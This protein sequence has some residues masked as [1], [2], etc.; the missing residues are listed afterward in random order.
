MEGGLI[1][2]VCGV[3][4]LVVIN[5]VRMVVA[6]L[7]CHQRADLVAARRAVRLAVGGYRAANDTTRPPGSAG[8][9][10]RRGPCTDFD[11]AGPGGRRR[12]L[13]FD[14]LRRR[15]HALP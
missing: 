3:F 7:R 11:C 8:G 2:G 14:R 12:R 10:C 5:R 13:C 6:G 15:V 9:V 1:A 4:W